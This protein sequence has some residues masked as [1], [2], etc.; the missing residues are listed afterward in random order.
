MIVA[1][2]A[3]YMSPEQ[4]RGL[5]ID[6][7]TD[8]W[9]F[10]CVLYEML[11][12]RPAF[13]RAT[14]TDTL[15]AIVER[16]PDWTA[17]PPD[18][19][20]GVERL[21][22]RCLEKDRRQR[23]RDIGDADTE[24]AVPAGALSR[25]PRWLKAI[26][27]VAV[28]AVAGTAVMLGRLTAPSAP[29]SSAVSLNLSP[30]EGLRFVETPVP[31]PDG[32]RIAF[33]TTA[34]DERPALWVRGLTDATPRRFAGTEGAARPFW[35]P[36]SRLIAFAADGRLKKVDADG[37]TIQTICVCVTELMGGT[38]G[39]NDVIVFA[40]FNR[41]PLHRV[42]ASASGGTSEPI[43]TLDQSR[44]ENSHRWPHFL[45]DGRHLLYTARSDVIS[46]TG[47]YS[48]ELGS[49]QRQWLVEAQSLALLCPTG[50]PAVRPRGNAPRTDL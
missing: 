22:R 27:A 34:P 4:A 11:A 26:V 17:L 8:I 35:S 45:P 2:T 33:V 43:T 40:P 10:G 12:G 25:T 6:K 14:L 5:A 7:R 36:D 44:N 9:A 21:L 42:L 30:P 29:V 16:E 28:I 31:S 37:G 41:S 38:W 1:G 24:P 49:D 50:P 3:A 13:A 47:V 46:N 19:P 20:P 18:T 48:M 32:T 15:A 23:L 39:A